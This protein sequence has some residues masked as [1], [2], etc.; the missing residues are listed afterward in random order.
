MSPLWNVKLHRLVISEDF[1]SIDPHSQRLILR[2]IRKKL[3]VD[4]KAYG[5]SLTGEFK[6]YWKLRVGDFRVI[7]KIKEKEIVVLVIKVGARRD[8]KVYKDLFFRIKKLKE[9]SSN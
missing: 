7:Y 5:N 9:A 2:E 6:G 1:K 4:P 3:A 8:Q